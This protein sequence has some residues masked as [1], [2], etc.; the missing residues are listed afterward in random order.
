M[1]DNDIENLG[2][3]DSHPLDLFLSM[4]DAPDSK[5]QYP[6]R[7]QNFFNFLNIKGDIKQQALSFV[8]FYKYQDNNG[9]KLEGRLLAFAKYQ[10]ERVD[11]KEISPA[12]VPN[13]FKAVK[14]FCQANRLYKNIEWKNISKTMPRGLNA[15][16]D[17]AP[18]LE[19]IQKLLEFPD[20]RIKPIVLTLVSSGIRIGAFETLKWKHITPI[21]DQKQQNS[22]I[23]QA[24]KILVYPGDREQY[25]SFLS[26]EA[27][28]AV[29]DWMD[30]RSL[31][32]EKITKES[33]VMRD[34]WQNGDEEGAANPKPLNSEAMTRLLNRGWQ[35]QKIRPQLQEG[36]KRHEFK[37][38]HGFRKYFKT[39][40]EQARIPSI[41]IELLMGHSL[42]VTD[43]Y[44]RFSEEQMLEDYLQGIEYLTVNQ[45]VVLIN[46]SIKQQ[47]EYMQQSLKEM[48]EKYKKEIG[49]LDEKYKDQL[50]QVSQDMVNA[51]KNRE[52]T[53]TQLNE[54]QSRFKL[55]HE[56]TTESLNEA[57]EVL[58]KN[59]VVI[60]NFNKVLLS[61]V[62]FMDTHPEHQQTIE[63]LLF[64]KGLD[65]PSSDDIKSLRNIMT[66]NSIN[67]SKK[68]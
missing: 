50:N 8:T 52:E 53:A 18:T 62:E 46:R 20:R 25:Y 60:K 68:E 43:S 34:I 67:P 36:Q 14:L 17:R 1:S 38:A 48:E 47:G 6:K 12:T 27:Y 63:S 21:Y 28:T 35:A 40:A 4:L 11:K 61:I 41:K 39:Q 65:L 32:G 55:H 9:E 37:T 7:L 56:T 15:A 5:R 19:E 23:I 64:K 31:C 2:S 22:N 10:K 58:A 13:Y 51:V 54:L 33:L 44:I 57:R 45:N 59:N 29:K 24:A 42:G 26:P 66:K 16:D 30:Y 3:D 49:L